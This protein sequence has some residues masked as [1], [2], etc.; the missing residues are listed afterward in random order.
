MSAKPRS[1][2][3]PDI[4]QIR[5]NIRG[6]WKASDFSL[7][8]DSINKLYRFYQPLIRIQKIF[9]QSNAYSNTAATYNKM[10]EYLVE[11]LFQSYDISNFS[12]DLIESKP[13]EDLHFSSNDLFT[14]TL[15]DIE[16]K[17]ID[18][19]S[20]GTIDLFG[21]QNVIIRIK[22]TMDGLI[23][24]KKENSQNDSTLQKRHNLIVSYLNRFDVQENE[25]NKLLLQDRINLE[26]LRKMI[27][28][29]KI[30]S[31]ELI[32]NSRINES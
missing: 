32:S 15:S 5:F 8:F 2:H 21:I 22:E 24:D 10:F 1:R 7:L 25:I 4:A 9:E 20:T 11:Y 23:K 29:S 31:V 13:T 12:K 18:Y 14:F 27:G 28:E 26:N 6:S 19:S 30:K 3:L 16:V 17:S